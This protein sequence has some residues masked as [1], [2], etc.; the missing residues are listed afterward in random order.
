MP[1][2]RTERTAAGGG[3]VLMLRFAATSVLNY[4]F[5]VALAW[6]LPRSEFGAVSVL[7]NV[8]LLAGMV[9]GAG[10][11]WV[12][13]RTIARDPDGWPPVF[14]SAI[15]VN[16]AIAVVLAGT[17]VVL[18]ATPRHVLPDAS[19]GVTVVVALTVLLLAVVAALGGA[20]H[21]SRRFDGLGAMQTAEIAVKAVAGLA[22]VALAG[23]GAAGVALGFLAGAAAAIGCAGWALRDRLPGWGPFAGAAVTRQALPAG[24]GTGSIAFLVT[25]DVLVL[26]VLGR[27][28]G[29][30]T[31]ALAAY[32]VAVI[33]AR[34]PYY[35]ANA[36]GDAAFPSMATGRTRRESHE[37]FVAVLR[38]V[39]LAL[40]PLQL[41]LLIAPATPLRVLFPGGYAD[42]ATLIRV[43]TA[44]TVALIAADLLVK[45]LYAQGLAGAVARRAPIAVLV[46]LTGLLLLVPRWGTTGAAVAFA[47]GATTGAVLLA[48]VYLTYHRPGR[49][50]GGTFAAYAVATGTLIAT[51]LF[52]PRLPAPADLLGIAAA[53]AAYVGLV[54]GLGL[55]RPREIAHVRAVAARF[56]RRS[57]LAPVCVLVTAVA[58]LWNL[59][60]SP[61]SQYDEVVYTRAAQQVATTGE[62]T[63]T[64]RP[65]FVHPPLSFLAQAG[66]L[67]TLGLDTAALGDAIIGSRVLAALAAAACVLVLAALVRR[68]VP[69]AGLRRRAV[70]TA[71]VVLLAATDPILLRYGRMAVI[72]PFALLGCLVTLWLAVALWRGPVLRYVVLVGAAT[73]LTL[74]TKE[75]ALFLLLTP[76][77][78]GLLG[79]D[80]AGLRRAGAALLTGLAVWL[81]FPLW[82]VQLGLGGEFLDVKVATAQ[83]LLGTVQITGWNRPE[84]SFAGAV[85][86]QAGQYAT[87]YLLLAAGAAALVWLV[88]RRPPESARWLL[89][90][91]LTS[92][93]FGAYTVLLGTLNEQFFVYL[94]PAAITGTVLVADA[95]TSAAR[96]PVLV[97][98]PLAAVLAVAA[99][100]W[101]RFLLPRN[102]ALLRATALVRATVPVCEPVNASGDPDKYQHLLPGYTVTSY[103]VGP[104]AVADGVHLF[105]LSDK[106]AALR[107]GTSNPQLTDWIRG[108]GTRVARFPSATYQGLELWRVPMNPGDPLADVRAT[109]AGSFALTSACTGFPVNGRWDKTQTGSPLTAGWA[110]NQVFE[111]VVRTPD[112]PLPVVARLAR[113]AAYRDAQLPPPDR[114]DRRLSD[115]VIAAAATRELGA[116]LGPPATM[117]DGQVRQPFA[118]AVLQHAPGSTVVSLAPVGRLALAEGLVDPPAAARLP[119]PAPALPTVAGPQEPSSV[120]PFL[121]SGAAALAAAALALL[122][123]RV[124][125]RREPAPE[126]RAEA[127]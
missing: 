88:L 3:V 54:V 9:L 101:G 68:L 113:T 5:G 73:G 16:L 29:I 59:W 52:A 1:D 124:R 61:D 91:L 77:V 108:N 94:M 26:S 45:A 123:T 127:V 78:F 43:L 58:L 49:V 115:P 67:R 103:A 74:L 47:L 6:L 31:A 11:P 55:I 40:V 41:V 34:I 85:L 102:D 12:L 33:L 104:A 70:L 95:V 4:G 75:V 107:Y 30:S 83:R 93:G 7:Q 89:A 25:L 112:G 46:Q 117:A 35:L 27:G 86:D 96:R 114:A 21:G 39:L 57:F 65:M 97:A 50:A 36:M 79:R 32:Q 72:E 62:L 121:R 24:A 48:A 125:R 84:T 69:M 111:G 119:Q 51:L 110:G 13:A 92:Y 44:G 18:Q 63:W 10:M 19:P 37:W 28:F 100:S 15:A 109:S 76:A 66:W 82:A 14:R 22:L 64:G 42:A 71:A 53:L 90:W 17:L 23:L 2:L 87:S 81:L 20:L 105:F 38:W 126:T 98:V 118:A 56:A 116:P 99:V 80:R 60:S 8:L 106:D 120:T 122:L